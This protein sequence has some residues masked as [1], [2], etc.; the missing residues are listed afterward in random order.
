M[1]EEKIKQIKDEIMKYLKRFPMIEDCKTGKLAKGILGD[2]LF[3]EYTVEKAIEMTIYETLEARRLEP[4][5]EKQLKKENKLKK[6][7]DEN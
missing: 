2:L 5:L 4:E 6:I 7:K 1:K 3:A